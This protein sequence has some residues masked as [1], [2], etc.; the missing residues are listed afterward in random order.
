MSDNLE[1]I[2]IGSSSGDELT[3]SINRIQN[4]RQQSEETQS[5]SLRSSLNI[6]KQ[7]DQYD[8]NDIDR[9]KIFEHIQNLDKIQTIQEVQIQ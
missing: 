8:F 6:D 3:E 1:Y 9:S 2:E 7:I 4:E 5:F